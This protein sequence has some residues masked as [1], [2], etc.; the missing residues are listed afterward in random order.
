MRYMED[1]SDDF[2]KELN[3]WVIKL[4]TTKVY[5]Y[6]HQHI[7]RFHQPLKY[8]STNTWRKETVPLQI[9][10]LLQ[11]KEYDMFV[12]YSPRARLTLAARLKAAATPNQIMLGRQLLAPWENE[13]YQSEQHLI[14]NTVTVQHHEGLSSEVDKT[15]KE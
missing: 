2:N 4:S 14:A 13:E 7:L 11:K 1:H 12:G 5:Y 15:M 3:M 9:Y 10:E 6:T 8:E